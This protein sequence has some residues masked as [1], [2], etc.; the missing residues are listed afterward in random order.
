MGIQVQEAAT[1]WAV[2]LISFSVG[3]FFGYSMYIRLGRSKQSYLK[4]KSGLLGADTYHLF[5]LVG[6]IFIVLALIALA[7]EVEMKQRL[8]LYPLAPSLIAAFL[9]GLSRP[10]WL[11]PGWLQ[12]LEQNHPDVYPLLKEVARE[13][14]GDDRESA[15]EW[16]KRMDAERGRNERVAEVC[17]RKG[18]PQ[19]QPY[20]PRCPSMKVPR[21]YRGQ[22]R[23]VQ[24]LPDKSKGRERQIEIYEQI[25]QS[26][27]WEQEP[28]FWAAVQERLGIAY[29]ERRRGKPGDNVEKAIA[30]Y[31]A[32]LEVLS[33]ERSPIDWAMAQNNLGAAYSKRTQGERAEWGVEIGSEW[34]TQT[35]QQRGSDN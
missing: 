16:S 31:T 25:L 19:Q 7:G 33:R 10:S 28:A 14:I 17:R 21:R 15:R 20:G 26:L 30:A 32:A 35:R 27:R 6:G 4:E 8:V 24:A 23:E 29:I 12:H 22:I 5:P 34:P 9:I 11:D 3:A 1:Q 18:M 2:F 13:E